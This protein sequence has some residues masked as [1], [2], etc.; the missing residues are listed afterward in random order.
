MHIETR[1]I[2]S[3]PS[4]KED[5]QNYAKAYVIEGVSG[6]AEKTLIDMKLRPEDA[7][8]LAY[9]IGNAFSD[10]YAGDE[11]PRNPPIDMEG[12]NMKGRV[13][14]SFRKKLVRGLSHDLS[15]ADNQLLINL[16]TGESF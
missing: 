14:I 6:I 1:Y 3:I 16:Q 10:H 2:E 9:Q 11:T 5:F 8:R 7:Y 13:I 12:V 15:P 4:V